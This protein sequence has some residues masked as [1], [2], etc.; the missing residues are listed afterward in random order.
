VVIFLLLIGANGTAA[1]PKLPVIGG[2]PALAVI[3]GE[4]LTLEEFDR[5]IAS[6]HEGT[7]DNA[8]RSRSNS[9][10]LLKRMINAKLIL[11]EA[12][13]IGLD[14]LPEVKNPVKVF[15]EDSLRGMLYGYHIRNIKKPDK[16][17]A[18]R[19]YM[20][21][22]KEI[23]VKSV[24]FEN[25]D[26][27]RRLE[28][29]V[30]AGGD[31]DQAANRALA[32]GEAT[33]SLEG[34]YMQYESLSPEVVRVVSTMKTGEVSPLLRIGNR[35][36]MLKLEDIR[37]PEDPAAREKAEKDA[38]QAKR[39]AALEAYTEELKKKYVIRNKKRFESLDYESAEPGFEKLLKD[40]RVVAEVKGEK[41]VTVMDLTE[42]LQR[43][44][45]HGAERAAQEKQINKRKSQVLEEIL[46]KRVTLKEAKLKKLDRTDYHKSRVEA[47]RNGILFATFVQKAVEP[48][49]KVE[50]AEIK[51]YLQE[52]IGEYTTPEMMRIDSLVFTKR[53]DAEEA[54]E[55]LRKGAD[56]QWMRANADGQVDATKAGNLLQF[57]G[58]MLVTATLPEGFQ[59]AVSGAAEGD[60][61]LHADAEGHSY[62]LYLRDVTPPKPQPFEEVESVIREKVH[63]E[64]RTQAL[65]DWEEK[66]RKASEVKVFATGEKLNRIVK[67]QAK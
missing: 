61:R 40:K 65:R 19:R 10:E 59:K 38:L 48:D 36:S 32:A 18:D 4:P 7:M 6:L 3:N 28:A 22:V 8:A 66:L 44:F 46:N 62:V 29:I 42:S 15:E 16:K 54:I 67:P 1:G 57:G 26:D 34:Q 52:H 63:L 55:K 51:A 43:R 49:V 31:F 41:P 13:N 33:G 23:K 25:E 12:R 30:T 5:T 9:A 64:K 11:Q 45:F 17:E 2:K 24:L 58:T 47:Y 20:A 60:Y 14:T 56:F 35:F 50:E 27:G 37:Y 21:A 39:V 53:E